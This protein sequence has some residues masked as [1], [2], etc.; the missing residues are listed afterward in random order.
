MG[1]YE[2]VM[3]DGSVKRAPGKCPKVPLSWAYGS[4]SHGFGT[5]KDGV[6]SCSWCGCIRRPVE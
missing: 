4:N 1:K 5:D 3:P 6:V 2:Y